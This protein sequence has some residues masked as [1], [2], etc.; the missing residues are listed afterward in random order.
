VST[1]VRV[2][3]MKA[4]DVEA[5]A[6]L[7]AGLPAAPQW[8]RDAYLAALDPQARSVRIALVAETAAAGLI[9]FTVASV[10]SPEAEL[11]SIAVLREF[12]RAGVARRL[13]EFLVAELA[14][15]GVK[16]VL[17]EVRASNEAA[18]SLYRVLGFAEAG[19][20]TGYYA[21]PAEDAVQMR[22]GIE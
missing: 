9:G 16:V 2:R 22:R 13:F 15:T 11:E 17:L 18:L 6:A 19:R 12:Q 3:R 14:A 5:V 1:E 10:I 7:A 4:A 21:H 20:R 8:Q